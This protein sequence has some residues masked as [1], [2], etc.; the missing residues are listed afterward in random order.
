V[1]GQ[2]GLAVAWDLD[3]DAFVAGGHAKLDRSFHAQRVGTFGGAQHEDGAVGQRPEPWGHEGSTGKL[4]A[5]KFYLDSAV[6]AGHECRAHHGGGHNGWG[7]AAQAIGFG[8][9]AGHD[10]P[11]VLP[12]V[13]VAADAQQRLRWDQV[14]GVPRQQNGDGIVGCSGRVEHGAPD[15]AA[16]RF[17]FLPVG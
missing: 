1:A 8:E 7:V 15:G 9:R 10:D 13:R 14:D 2:H 16:E 5:K 11:E 6:E 4:L 3:L 17:W 12:P